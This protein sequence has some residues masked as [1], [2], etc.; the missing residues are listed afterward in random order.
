MS[1][2]NYN[3]AGSRSYGL[4]QIKKSTARLMGYAGSGK[5]LQTPQI[6]AHYAGLYL[7]YQLYRYN[8]DVGCAI[9]AYNAGTCR[10]NAKGLILNRKYVEKVL[11]RWEI[12][13]ARASKEPR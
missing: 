13:E 6:N 1:A 9:S 2:V 7:R 11:E 8:G 12:E 10:H 4:C 5:D 3:D